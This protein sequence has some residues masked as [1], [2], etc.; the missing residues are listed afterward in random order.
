MGR[1]GMDLGRG[2]PGGGN[3]PTC[4]GKTAAHSSK[5]LTDSE[6]WYKYDDD[7]IKFS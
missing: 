7:T 4:V 3:T 6:F 2:R 5:V 1:N